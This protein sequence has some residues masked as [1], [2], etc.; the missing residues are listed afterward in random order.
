MSGL[1]GRI[2]RLEKRARRGPAPRF[3]TAYPSPQYEES[4]IE[5]LD[6]DLY[7]LH[8]WVPHVDASIWEYLT[9]EMQGMLRPSDYI[10]VE[11][12]RPRRLLLDEFGRDT[13]IWEF[14][15]YGGRWVRQEEQP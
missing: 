15:D 14:Q 2:N 8:V 11:H 6:S 10:R 1:Q 12:G 13:G 7:R 4:R 9:D 5:K 3:F